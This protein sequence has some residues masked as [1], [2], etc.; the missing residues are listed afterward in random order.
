MDEFTP[1]NVHH[2]RVRGEIKWPALI[3]SFFV[4]PHEDTMGGE[5]LV[6]FSKD[7]L[8]PCNKW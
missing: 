2:F 5:V 3:C 7:F 1:F 8:L 4:L 6:Y